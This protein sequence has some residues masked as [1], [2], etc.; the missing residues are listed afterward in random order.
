ML[1]SVIIPTY[2][3]P[4]LLSDAIESVR[5]QTYDPVEL[6][7]VDDHSPVPV[8]SELDVAAGD[9][10]RRLR[11]VRHDENRGANA[12]RNTGSRAAEGDVLAVLDDDDV[13]KPTF[14]ERVVGAFETAPSEPN[15]VTTGVESVDGNG[16]LLSVI[17]P[18]FGDDPL[19]DLLAGEL[20]GSFSRFAVRASVVEAAGLPDERFPC[21]QDWEWQF[22]LARHGAFHAIPD[23][24]VVHRIGD[25]DQITDDYEARRDVAYPLFLE[26]HRD[27]V[28]ERGR[29]DER[30]F[31]ALLSRSLGQSALRNG[32]RGE[33]VRLLAASLRWNPLVPRTLLFFGF[34]VAGR[35]GLET[36]RSVKQGVVRRLH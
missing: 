8:E 17:R 25:H 36:A 7:V 33:A 35:S 30:R 10:L 16:E 28:A 4:D 31:L 21:W 27:H 13:W 3:R 24:L 32:Y 18:S 26:K 11:F 22:R 14:V 6:V 20:A 23:A 29:W 2:G 5:A 19:D 9:D 34:A 15:V 1:V 12:A